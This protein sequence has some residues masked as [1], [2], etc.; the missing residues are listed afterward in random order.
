MGIR[1]R[2]DVFQVPGTHIHP[3]SL[4]PLLVIDMKAR[5]QSFINTI[6]NIHTPIMHPSFCG[7]SRPHVPLAIRAP[8]GAPLSLLQPCVWGEGAFGGTQAF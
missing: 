1:W 3:I 4:H 8:Q 5:Y 2:I 7:V 6:N